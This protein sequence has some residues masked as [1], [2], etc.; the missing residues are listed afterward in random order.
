[1][2][3]I[4]SITSIFNEQYLIEFAK[5]ALLAIIF[6]VFIF[7]ILFLTHKL[8]KNNEKFS[9]YLNN[10]K[11]YI[12]VFLIVSLSVMSISIATNANI[13]AQNEIFIQKANNQPIF[14][15]EET[16]Y[17]NG[18][19]EK[20]EV[21]NVGAPLNNF[22]S[23]SITFIKIH[24]RK[25]NKFKEIKVP[26]SYYDIATKS[27]NESEL[28]EFF[29]G[30]TVPENGN[31]FRLTESIGGFY[32]SLRDNNISGGINYEK[33]VYITYEDIYGD[34]H[35][36]LYLISDL[37]PSKISNEQKRKI[38]MDYYSSKYYLTVEDLTAD[39]LYNILIAQYQ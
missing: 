32:D 28:I 13:I 17:S 11:I 33:Y 26:I 1:M 25:D 37:N 36:D 23:A 16:R 4:M 21:Y 14:I 38:L 34:E 8:Q 12:E 10:N 22:F 24:G 30:D 35:N 9:E 20:L 7:I 18:Y 39:K 31:Y 19:Y 3:F 6:I 15:F 29:Y 5:N 27:E 2:D